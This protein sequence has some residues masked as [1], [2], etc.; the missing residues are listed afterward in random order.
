MKQGLSLEQLRIAVHALREKNI[1]PLIITSS[2]QAKAMNLADKMIGLKSNWRVG[3]TYYKM[4]SHP[5]AFKGGGG[6]G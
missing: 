5:S 1:P 3:D 4:R 2:K 6:G